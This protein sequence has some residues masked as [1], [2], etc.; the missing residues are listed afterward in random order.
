M[1]AHVST[2]ILRR[3]SEFVL[4]IDLRYLTRAP[5]THDIMH[6]KLDQRKLEMTYPTFRL[7]VPGIYSVHNST[8]KRPNAA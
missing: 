6:F 4:L 2:I 3:I 1:H 8:V 7:K 5:Y